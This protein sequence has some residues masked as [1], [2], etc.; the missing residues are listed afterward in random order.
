MSLDNAKG[1]LKILG[2][3]CIILGV[4][5]IIVGLVLFASGSV[6]GAELF[7]G[8]FTSAEEATAAGALTA[9][10]YFGGFLALISGIID[11]LQGIFSVRASN[12]F[13]KI[14]P[15]YVFSIIGLAL[16]II[17]LILEIVNGVTSGGAFDLTP[18][19]HDI[20]GIVFSGCILYAAKT[21]KDNA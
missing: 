2:I 1:T 10:V 6:I 14:Q 21:I 12:D 5:G 7:S 17:S 20:C 18:I 16:A 19:I 9:I 13:S 4:L 15:A 11:L 8:T 3:L